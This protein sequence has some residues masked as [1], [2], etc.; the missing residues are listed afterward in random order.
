MI[1][2]RGRTKNIVIEPET[3]KSILELAMEHNVDWGFSCTRGTCARCRC[4]VETGRELLSE[5]TDAEWARLDE[6]ELEEGYRL[7]CQ[8]VVTKLGTLKALNKTYF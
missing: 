5:P 1:E 8:A 6:E 7:G 3:G 2:L 4:Y